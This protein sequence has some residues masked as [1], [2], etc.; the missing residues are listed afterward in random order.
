MNKGTRQILTTVRDRVVETDWTQGAYKKPVGRTRK[1]ETF[2]LVGLIND[3][4]GLEPAQLDGSRTRLF[5]YG[6]ISRRRS[7]EGR[8]AGAISALLSE[9]GTFWPSVE[10]W[11]DYPSRKR[12]EVVALLDK[13]LDQ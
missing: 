8:V 9:L 7:K 3:T 5:T 6:E 1:K 4:A 13:V 12:D 2:C 11:N 10:N